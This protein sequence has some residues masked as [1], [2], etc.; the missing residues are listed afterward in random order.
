MPFATVFPRTSS[1]SVS[2]STISSVSVS[3]ASRKRFSALRALRAK[4]RKPSS[5][6]RVFSRPLCT[7]CALFQP[8]MPGALAPEVAGQREQQRQRPFHEVAVVVLADAKALQDVHGLRLRDLL[9]EIADD[10]RADAGDLEAC[11]GVYSARRSRM[12]SNAGLTSTDVP[13][14]RLDLRG[15]AQSGP[16]AIEIERAAGRLH[17]VAGCLRRASRA[18]PR[19]LRPRGLSVAG[20]GCCRSGRAAR[21]RSVRGR[22]PRSPSPRRR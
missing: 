7:S 2:M 14:A 9:G 8:R 19:A 13:S 21:G 4:S 1:R 15:A 11:S 3:S 20:I 16:P 10:L 6:G 22:S 5:P 12:I 17:N 18:G